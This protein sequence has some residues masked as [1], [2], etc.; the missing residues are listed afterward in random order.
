[1]SKCYICDKCGA[2]I[3]RISLSEDKNHAVRDGV[4]RVLV[5]GCGMNVDLDLCED[6]FHGLAYYLGLNP[7]D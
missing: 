6:C 4:P 3:K 5:Q 7:D 2:K 1:M